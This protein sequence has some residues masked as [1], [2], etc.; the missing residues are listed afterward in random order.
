MIVLNESKYSEE[1][2]DIIK[3]SNKSNKELAEELNLKWYTI[4]NLRQRLIGSSST[5]I[6][7]LNDKEKESLINDFKNGDSIQALTKKYKKGKQWISKFLNSKGLKTDR[8]LSEK[9]IEIILEY[10]NKELASDV[11]KRANCS[12][13][14]VFAVYKR[15]NKDNY[16]KVYEHLK[17]FDNINTDD[18]AYFLGFIAADGCIYHKEDDEKERNFLSIALQRRDR[19]ILEKFYEFINKNNGRY[20][21]DYTDKKG[22]EY[23]EIQIGGKYLTDSLSKYNIVPNKTW[24]YFPVDLQDDKLMF[25]FLRGFFDGDGAIT[26]ASHKNKQKSNLPSSYCIS[27]VGNYKCLK[28]IKDFIEKYN[29]KSSLIEDKREYSNSFYSLN[30]SETSSIYLLLKHMYK[31]NTVC[32][33]RKLEKANNFINEFEANIQKRIKYDKTKQLF[34]DCPL[35]K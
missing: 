24:T 35:Y 15:F 34:N 32:L 29:I 26:N 11:A 4:R 17:Y 25:S 7:T 33:D 23:S 5:L 10:F 28:F 16:K 8:N 22:R 9:Q 18:K 6:K 19:Y 14:A 1:I 2:L 21:Y 20:I 27:F 13:S 12:E 31:N 30:I 3:N